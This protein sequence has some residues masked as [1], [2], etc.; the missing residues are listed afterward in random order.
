VL[1]EK[2]DVTIF[3]QQSTL[4]NISIMIDTTQEFATD[5]KEYTMGDIGRAEVGPLFFEP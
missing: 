2:P 3:I 1:T 5:E 4:T